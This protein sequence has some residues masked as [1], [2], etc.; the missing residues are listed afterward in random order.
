MDERL[1]A[2]LETMMARHGIAT[3]DIEEGDVSVSLRKGRQAMP[4]ASAKTQQKG[5]LVIHAAAIGRFRL[6]NGGGIDLG[7]FPR[8]VRKGEIVAFLDAGGLLRPVAAPEGGVVGM[9]LVGEGEL[10]GYG[11]RLF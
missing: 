4:T 3:L 7:R 10:I 11:D 8:N 6:A 5:T 9:P 2:E 1:I